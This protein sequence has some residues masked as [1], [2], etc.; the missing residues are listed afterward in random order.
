MPSVISYGI[1]VDL[2]GGAIGWAMECYQRGILDENDTGGL[3]LEWGDAEV[4]LELIRMIDYREGIGDL[5]AEGCA[6]AAD[7]LGRDSSYYAMHLKGQ[8]LYEPCRGSNGW[9]LGAATST[10]GGG[11]TTGAIVLETTPGLDPEKGK[12]GLRC[13]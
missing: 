11:H 9:L 3:K 8:D 6:R 5:L 7:I 1:D 13:G 4:A 10:R 2:A 12:A